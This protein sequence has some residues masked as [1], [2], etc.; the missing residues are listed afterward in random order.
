MLAPCRPIVS[1]RGSI[2]YGVAKGLAN[3][4]IPLV[5]QSHNHLKTTQQF[6]EYMKKVNLEPGE[7]MTSYVVKVLFTSVPVDPSIAIVK[8]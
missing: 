6:M 1:G 7:V 8:V 4:I 5:G 3:I 2:T